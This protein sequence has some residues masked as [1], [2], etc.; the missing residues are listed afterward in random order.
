MCCRAHKNVCVFGCGKFLADLVNNRDILNYLGANLLSDSDEGKHGTILYGLPVLPPDE[1]YGLADLV[2]IFCVGKP[3]L[4]FD[5][6]RDLNAIKFQI[7]D[8]NAEYDIQNACSFEQNAILDVYDILADDLSREAYANE[9][10]FRCAGRPR[11]REAAVNDRFR[12]DFLRLTRHESFVECGSFYGYEIGEFIKTVR[13]R[14]QSIVGFEPMRDAYEALLKKYGDPRVS[15]R[16]AAVGDSTETVYIDALSPVGA[17]IRDSVSD[18]TRQ[19]RM[20][21]LDDE[22][23]ECSFL[24]MNVEGSEAAAIRGGGGVI[25]KNRPKI[26]LDLNHRFQDFW[27][28]PLLLKSIVPDYKI[29]I[30]PYKTGLSK[31][32]KARQL[33]SVQYAIA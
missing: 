17:N 13:N 10:L 12:Y 5:R 31:D 21:R 19:C 18:L 6:F 20:V 24:A 30:R 8:V 16:N 15:F 23:Q 25:S 4:L 29:F 22:I 3:D 14:F 11:D 9:L 27:E 32:G 33:F 2:V 7:Y 28:L 26:M 1:L